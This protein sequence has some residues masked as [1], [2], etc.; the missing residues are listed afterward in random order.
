VADETTAAIDR[1]FDFIDKGVEVA[2]RTFNRGQQT[3]DLH[4]ARRTK[5]EVI[6]AE[7]T[8]KVPK[9]DTVKTAGTA[10]V[11]KPHFY[12][13]EATDPK[14]GGA[15]FVVTDG[16]SARTECSTRE[17]ASKILLALEKAP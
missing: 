16:G 10:V 4:R 2:D 3:A 15:I 5:R 9:K 6:E 13:V 1:I 11:R 8:T 17:F 7:A 12:I 14:S